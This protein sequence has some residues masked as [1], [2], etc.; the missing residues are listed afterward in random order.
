VAKFAPTGKYVASG[1]ASSSFPSWQWRAGQTPLCPSCT[2]HTCHTFADA[3]G[4]VRVWAY[5]HAEQLLKYELP[6]IGGEVEDLA[7]DSESKRIAAVGGGAAKAKFFMW[8]TGS[9]LGEVVPHTK[10]NLTVDFKPTRPFRAVLGGEDF[11]LSFYQGPPFK[12]VPLG[13]RPSTSLLVSCAD[14]ASASAAG[15][16]RASRSTQTSSTAPGS[17]RMALASCQSLQTSQA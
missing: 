2:C 15:S 9:Q 12:S 3:S 4:K 1:G 17:L 11:Q 8:D 16:T 13:G 14:H 7:W 5:T 10:K 6:S